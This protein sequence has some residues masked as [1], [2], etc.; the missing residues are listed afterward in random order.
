EDD[1]DTRIEPY[2]ELVLLA[3]QDHRQHDRVHGFEIG[4]E[5]H[6][7]RRQLA[8]HRQ[9]KRKRQQ[10][11]DDRQHQQQHRV[12]QVRDR[13][14]AFAV[15]EQ[16]N[17][18]QEHGAGAEFDAG[19]GQRAAPVGHALVERAEGGAERRRQHAHCDTE[20]H[21][22]GNAAHDQRD[23]RHHRHADQQFTRNEFPS[24]HPRLD[25]CEEH[26]RERN[27]GRSNRRI[28]KLDRGV[29]R[30][31]VQRHQ[32]ADARV[33]REPARRHRAQFTPYLR[34]QQ[35][36]NGD[37][38]HPPPYELQCGQRNQL[39][40]DGGESPQHHAEVELPL[41]FGLWG[42]GDA[43]TKNE[44]RRTTRRPNVN[45]LRS[46]DN[47]CAFAGLRML[48]RTPVQ[49]FSFSWLGATSAASAAAGAATTPSTAAPTP[50][51]SNGPFSTPASGCFRVP[52]RYNGER[53]D[54]TRMPLLCGCISR[55]S[56]SSLR[57][58]LPSTSMRIVSAS[59]KNRR[60]RH[61]PSF[62]T[63]SAA[64]QLISS[65]LSP[66]SL[67]TMMLPML[68]PASSS[69]SLLTA[70][71]LTSSLTSPS[72]VPSS[73]ATELPLPFSAASPLIWPRLVC[74]RST[75]GNSLLSLRCRSFS[76]AS[77]CIGFSRP[78]SE[79]FAF[80]S[81]PAAESASGSSA[82][83]P[84]FKTTCVD[85]SLIGRAPLRTMRL[86]VKCTSASIVRQRVVS[87]VSTGSS[88]SAGCFCVSPRLA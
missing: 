16:S 71:L 22:R 21:V 77:P 73:R 49:A 41:R 72:E 83:M 47:Q 68:S 42:H 61:T 10:R 53:S 69:S 64:A 84:S 40:E 28:G 54:R 81:P 9:R 23:T 18:C 2:V 14:R 60:G 35:Q 52:R 43:D 86:L 59:T 76:V 12:M 87:K 45:Y 19:D 80:R 32:Y 11:A 25:D 78:S 79:I 29:E 55:S 48:A 82:S 1:R 67:V 85:R 74:I 6:G 56:V 51:A 88:L 5:L 70:P 27:A 3:Q 7:V 62:A 50:R 34:Q 17:K 46:P 24:H 63:R 44:G 13:E 15:P 8:Q 36:C 58:M 37:D 38:Q 57:L 66:A 75:V 65:G 30:Q 4:R 33:G 31:P 20:A 39:A 26:R